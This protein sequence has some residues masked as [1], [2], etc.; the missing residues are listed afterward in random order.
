MAIVADVRQIGES[1]WIAS[2]LTI[3]HA[4]AEFS[5]AAAAAEWLSP[6]MRHRFFPSQ[7]IQLRRTKGWRLPP[8]TIVVARPSRYGNPYRVDDYRIDYC[9]ASEERLHEMATSDFRGLVDGRWADQHPYPSLAELEAALAGRNLACWCKP[10]FAC[11]ADVLLELVNPDP[12]GA[13]E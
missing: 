7:R 9:D 3:G 10:E 2:D 1:L 13:T 11:H 6:A 8:S 5:S 12:S 4:T